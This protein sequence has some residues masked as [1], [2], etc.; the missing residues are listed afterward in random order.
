M[1]ARCRNVIAFVG[2]LLPK[3]VNTVPA[4]N[5]GRPIL[6]IM[7]MADG[8]TVDQII[9]KRTADIGACEA[10]ATSERIKIEDSFTL[11]L[12]V[13]EYAKGLVLRGPSGLKAM[14]LL[15]IEGDERVCKHKAQINAD[16]A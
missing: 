2:Q 15:P 1:E 12:P 13:L 4:H 8:P 6:R 7:F 14:L 11:N 16:V 9:K 10:T 3:H 5:E